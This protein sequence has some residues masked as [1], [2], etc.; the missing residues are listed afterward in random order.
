MN[1]NL[2]H[3]QRLVELPPESASGRIGAAWALIRANL[4]T[5]KKL[6]EVYAAAE[7]DRLGVTYAQFKV[8]VHRLRKRD[9]HGE[10]A[11]FVDYARRVSVCRAEPSTSAPAMDAQPLSKGQYDPLRNVR[12]QHGR[13]SG[14]DYDPFPKKKLIE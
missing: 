6:G 13:K 2:R 9:L 1:S 5:G 10:V 3:L 12:E 14:F 8:Y 4:A 7:Q 11:P